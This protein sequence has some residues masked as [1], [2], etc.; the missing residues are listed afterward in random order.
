MGYWKNFRPPAFPSIQGVREYSYGRFG[1]FTDPEGNRVDFGSRL[2]RE[3]RCDAESKRC[4]TGA[5]RCAF[6]FSCS[7]CFFNMVRTIRTLAHQYP[8]VSERDARA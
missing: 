6:V 8:A 5:S 1:W 7:A 4:Y 3:P 2:T